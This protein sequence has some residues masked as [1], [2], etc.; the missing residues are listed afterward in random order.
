[1]RGIVGLPASG[2]RGQVVSASYKSYCLRGA[3]VLT[4]GKKEGGAGTGCF[5][6][7]KNT[8]I[9]RDANRRCFLGIIL[10]EYS[11]RSHMVI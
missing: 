2:R 5:I 11:A 1:M 3:R 9:F 7:L 4:Q 6:Y 8:I 10:A